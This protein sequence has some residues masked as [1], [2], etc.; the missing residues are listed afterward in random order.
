MPITV[1]QTYPWTTVTGEDTSGWGAGGQLA[2]LGGIDFNA[3][4]NLKKALQPKAP[5]PQL[6]GGYQR[7]SGGPVSPV[8]N[9]IRAMNDWRNYFD[10]LLARGDFR[11]VEY[12]AHPYRNVVVAGSMMGKNLAAPSDP[13]LDMYR[14]AASSDQ[15]TR[16]AQLAGLAQP[17][18]SQ[19][20]IAQ[21]AYGYSPAYGYGVTEEKRK[22]GV[23]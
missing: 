15:P 13:W 6:G 23:T 16:S 12:S 4:I 18:E 14:A 11:P 22:G 5:G 17:E 1:G 19:A 9:D 8:A 20:E 7:P 10:T 3:L 2:G 21:R